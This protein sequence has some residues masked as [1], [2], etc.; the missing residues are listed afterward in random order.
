MSREFHLGDVLSVT[1]RIL[2]SPRA[3]EGLQ[4]I[5]EYMAGEGVWTHQLV[6]VSEEC[7]PW[8]FRQ[9]PQLQGISDEG[10]GPDNWR[11]WLDGLVKEHGEYLEVEPIPKD[12]HA[13]K[14]PID[15]AVEMFGKGRVI[16]V[17]EEGE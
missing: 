13:H 2:V 17:R 12:D 14:N 9:H 11:V 6:R 8:L 4:D 1:G 7:K 10:I 5:L 16:V 15:E 3:M